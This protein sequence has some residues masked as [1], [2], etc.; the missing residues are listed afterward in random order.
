MIYP[1]DGAGTMRNNK[2][3]IGITGGSG[4]GKTTVSDILR[5]NGV[6]VIDADIVAREVVERGKPALSEIAAEFDGVILPSGELDRKKLGSI[7]FSDRKKLE[8]LNKITHKYI[9]A[10][11]YK[12]IDECEGKCCAVDGAALFESGIDSE[13]DY[14]CAVTADREVRIRRITARDGLSD[15]QAKKRID[16]QMSDEEYA[17]KCDFI[18]RNNGSLSDTENDVMCCLNKINGRADEEKA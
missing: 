17:Q 10:R 14:M 3:I 2:V 8:K 16:S 15:E 13:C 12:L 6:A 18:I 9:T 7:V 4:A 5:R 1:R 11:I